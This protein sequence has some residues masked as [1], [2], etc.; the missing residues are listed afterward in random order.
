MK[1]FIP[2]L[3][4]SERLFFSAV[5]PM[6]KDKFPKIAYA[7]ARLDY[8]SD[9]LGFDTPMSMDHGWEPKISLYISEENYEAYHDKLDDYFANHLPFNVLGFPTNFAEPYA[10]GGVISYKDT[11][12]I[13]HMIEITTPEKWF[14]NYLGVDIDHKISLK[15]WLTIP[16]QRLATLQAG[17]I[18][19]DD[20]GIITEFRDKMRWY[21]QDIWLYLLANQWQRIDQDEPFIGRTG[22]VGDELGSQLIAARLVQDLK[23]L[24]F[25]MRRIY[26]P[27]RKW[28]GSAFQRLKVAPMVVPIFQNILACKNWEE[29]EKHLSKAYLLFSQAHDKLG[30]THFIEPIISNFYD[31]PFLVPHAARFANALYAQIKDP[32]VMALQRNLGNIDQ[33]CD[34]TDLLENIEACKKLRTLYE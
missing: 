12:P 7:A 32:E 1:K 6:M 23:L 15:L 3:E 9:V 11:Y 21:P 31:R 8:G 14:S 18:Y 10:D 26:P 16:Q 27:Y 22:S 19:H 20:P 33:I 30:F 13:H 34:N 17:R 5:K 25:L 2:G 28:F 24:G 29:R 4:L